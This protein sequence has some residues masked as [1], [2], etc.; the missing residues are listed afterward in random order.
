MLSRAFSGSEPGI[1]CYGFPDDWHRLLHCVTIS[2]STREAA[3]LVDG[4]LHNGAVEST[5]YSTDTHGFTE[6][7]FAVT[8][9]IQVA[10]APRTRF[11]QG[12]Q[13]YAFA[14]M[15][16][17]G[18]TAHARSPVKRLNRGLIE[19]QRK[20]VL[21][22]IG[23]LKQKRVTAST[24]RRRLNFYS[25]HHPGSRYCTLLGS[26]LL[27]SLFRQA[28]SPPQNRLPKLVHYLAQATASPR[29][30]SADAGGLGPHFL[31]QR[32]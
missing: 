21:R 15:D 12:Q 7:D 20:I 25:Q 4:L 23:S 14:G 6:V 17:P 8:H 22:L 16:V 13:P 32:P 5:I 28:F 30:A 27:L 29:Q 26:L 3:Y 19:A 24:V 2:A 1:G 31:A 9:L 11:F 18:L 10:F